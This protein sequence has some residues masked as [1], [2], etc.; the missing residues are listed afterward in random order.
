MSTAI[1]NKCTHISTIAWY[2]CAGAWDIIFTWSGCSSDGRAI[3]VHPQCTLCRVCALDLF[4]FLCSDAA[5]SS[6]SLVEKLKWAKNSTK[7][8]KLQ[9]KDQTVEEEKRERERQRGWKGEN[10]HINNA[11]E[12]ERQQKCF[13]MWLCHRRAQ[14]SIALRV[15][16]SLPSN[17]HQVGASEQANDSRPDTSTLKKIS[18][19]ANESKA[20]SMNTLFHKWIW[21]EAQQRP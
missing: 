6:A 5:F 18:Y 4:A 10:R 1:D 12:M 11:N 16:S 7:T 21:N 14:S 19:A 8:F 15:T 13:L 9:S 3:V 17:E 2:I 20:L